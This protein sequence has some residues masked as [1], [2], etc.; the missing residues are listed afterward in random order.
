M[1]NTQCGKS[2][3]HEIFPKLFKNVNANKNEVDPFHDREWIPGMCHENKQEDS[4]RWD[5]ELAIKNLKLQILTSKLSRQHGCTGRFDKIY[6]IM[7]ELLYIKFIYSEKATKV[8]EISTQLLSSVVP[9]GSKL[10]ILQDFVAS[11][12][13]MNFTCNERSKLM[14]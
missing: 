4:N 5:R 13:Y 9:V 10:E 12:E 8:C 11:S 7:I 14:K 6:L 2:D 3:F 1:V